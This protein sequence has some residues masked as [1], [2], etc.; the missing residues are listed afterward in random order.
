LAA[1]RCQSGSAVFDHEAGHGFGFPFQQMSDPGITEARD[2]L[3]IGRKTFLEAGL[4]RVLMFMQQLQLSGG[5]LQRTGPA[6]QEGSL[7]SRF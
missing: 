4:S 2:G 1:R 6:A 3:Y 7:A 5:G